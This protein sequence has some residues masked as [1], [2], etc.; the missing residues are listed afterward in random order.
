MKAVRVEWVG[1]HYKS[2][3]LYPRT[4]LPL[5][6]DLASVTRITSMQ[7]VGLGGYTMAVKGKVKEEGG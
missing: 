3:D 6:S 2:F 5:W 1:L 4:G 7:I